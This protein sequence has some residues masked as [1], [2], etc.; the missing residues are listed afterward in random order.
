VEEIENNLRFAGQYYDAETGLHYNWNRYYDPETGRYMRVDPVGEGLNLYLYVKNNPLKYIDPRGLTAVKPETGFWGKVG[1][2]AKGAY[3]EWASSLNEAANPLGT[4]IDPHTGK[5]SLKS[6]PGRSLN[7]PFD[8][9]GGYTK[10]GT[11]VLKIPVVTKAFDKVKNVAKNLISKVFPASKST[12]I[13]KYDSVFA[14]KQG[15]NAKNVVP[16]SFVVVRGGQA[17]MSGPGNTFSGSMGSTLSEAASGVPHG[18]VRVTT[19]GQIRAGGGVVELVP[20]TTR[21]GVI[22]VR[23]VNVTEGGSTVFSEFIQSPVPKASR[24]K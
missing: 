8:P 21:S 20:E 7:I 12:A 2:L 3:N 4:E 24:I 5:L 16:D 14:L 15:A 22:N 1:Q 17:P 10:L 18:S 19:A 13:V 9:I 23:H 6:I 11:K